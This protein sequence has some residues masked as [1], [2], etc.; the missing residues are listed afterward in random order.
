LLTFA[1]C[2][3]RPVGEHKH[4]HIDIELPHRRHHHHEP[5][6]LYQRR[7]YDTEHT[8]ITVELPHHRRHQHETEIDFSERQYRSKFQPNY[9]EEVRISETTVDPALRFQATT[10]RE[11]SRVAAT[12]VDAP[13]FQSEHRPQA[14]VSGTTVDGPSSQPAYQQQTRV[15]EYSVDAPRFSAPLRQ[16]VHITEE[17]VDVPRHTSSKMGYYDEDG[18]SHL[19]NQSHRP[20]SPKR[21]PGHYHSFRHGLHRAADRVLGRHHHH[22]HEHHNEH[23]VHRPQSQHIIRQEKVELTVGREPAPARASAPEP[24]SY[25]PNTVTIPCHHIRVGDLLILQGRPCQVIRITTS[26]AT[27]QHRY[28]GVDLFTKQLHEESSF[29]SNPSPSV[30]VQTMLGPVFKQYRVLD[31]QEGTGKLS[32]MNAIR[33]SAN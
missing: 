7:R 6:E 29:I 23:H 31:L 13:R 20:Q 27:G 5:A 18:K 26:S 17:T 33:I 32:V 14:Y 2:I 16:K 12:T 4:T 10:H 21:L 15:E 19:L 3:N 24:A 9:R 22:H 8:D 1:S 11:G 25:S 28:L 30:I